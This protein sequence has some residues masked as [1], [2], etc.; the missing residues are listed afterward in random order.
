ML[1]QIS[2]SLRVLASQLSAQ[3]GK[4]IPANVIRH[5]DIDRIFCLGVSSLPAHRLLVVVSEHPV[6]APRT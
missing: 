6:F 1:G 3:H 2:E 4:P 5:R